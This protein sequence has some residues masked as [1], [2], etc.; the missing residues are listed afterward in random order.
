MQYL[1]LLTQIQKIINIGSDNTYS[2]N[3]LIDPRW[4][5][6]ISYKRPGEPDCTWADIS[7]AKDLL[8]WSPSVSLQAGVTK[9]I[10]NIDYWKRYLFGMSNQLLMQQKLV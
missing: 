4:R 6:C 1:Q 9:L 2:I 3:D 8:N 10:E 5:G 7:K